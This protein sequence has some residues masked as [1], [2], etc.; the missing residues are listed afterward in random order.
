VEG[1]ERPDRAR[2][3]AGRLSDPAALWGDTD[4]DAIVPHYRPIYDELVSLLDPRPG[5]RWLDVACGTGEI[6]LRAARAGADVHAQDL[7]PAMVERARAKAAAEGA[8]VEFAVCDCARLPYADASF[9]VVVSNF[10]LVFAA[11]QRAVAGEV[12]RVCRGRLGFTAWHEL[13]ALTDL[14]RRLG[15]EPAASDRAVWADRPGALLGDSFE[16]TVHE[17]VWHLRGESGQAVLDFWERT[18]PPTKAYLASLD[19]SKRVEARSALVEHWE[20]YRANGGVDEPRP[21][22]IVLGRRR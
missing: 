13:P 5:E 1:P 17:R 15:R 9:D 4:Y 11:N 19:E 6:A 7:A 22:A 18:A 3:G 20:G 2:K 8:R 21:F 10:G 12:A 16:L 14:Y